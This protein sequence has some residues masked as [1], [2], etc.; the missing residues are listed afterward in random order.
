MFIVH[1]RGEQLHA[2]VL[3]IE[4]PQE[5]ARI[6]QQG[7]EALLQHFLFASAL[8]FPGNIA[9]K[10]YVVEFFGVYPV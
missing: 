2:A 10:T 9:D 8:V 4:T 6:L 7:I 1:H 5:V 3:D